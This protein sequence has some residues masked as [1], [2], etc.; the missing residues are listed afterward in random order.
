VEKRIKQTAEL[1][2][3]RVTIYM[4]QEPGSSGVNTIDH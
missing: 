1:D 2:G 4:E 3:K